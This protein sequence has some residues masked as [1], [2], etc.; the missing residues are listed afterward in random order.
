MTLTSLSQTTLLALAIGATGCVVYDNNCDLDE[1]PLRAGDTGGAGIVDDGEEAGPLLLVDPDT[2]APGETLIAAVVLDPDS[3]E[4]V[5]FSAVTEV[6]FSAGI[7]VCSEQAR[8]GELLLSLVVDEA[9]VPGSVDLM[10]VLEGGE[11]VV[12]EDAVDIVDP[13]LVGGD[14]SEEPP[15]DE[16]PEEE[17]P[18]GFVEDDGAPGEEAPE[19][20]DPCR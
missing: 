20:E 14:A 3:P 2:V 1:K 15:E 10:L 16:E 8:D 13:G 18:G 6:R 17:D 11:R 4:P 5:E 12:V 19:R 7:A 9:A